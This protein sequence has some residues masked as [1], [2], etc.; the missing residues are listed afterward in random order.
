M[1]ASVLPNHPP[2]LGC[3]LS[4]IGEFAVLGG[5]GPRVVAA[6]AAPV[7]FDRNAGDGVFESDTP[8]GSA[9]R[10]Y[11]RDPQSET[12]RGHGRRQLKKV[13]ARWQLKQ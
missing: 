5:D 3:G 1:L 7:Q 6:V 11:L 10:T 2:S 4:A 8:D 13:Q 9:H 12:L